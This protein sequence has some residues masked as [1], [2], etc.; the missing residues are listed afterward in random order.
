[1]KV[2]AAFDPNDYHHPIGVYL[3]GLSNSYAEW[4]T[5]GDGTISF[6]NSLGKSF[7]IDISD[8]ST[9]RDILSVEIKSV[10]Y[11]TFLEMN[12]RF[13]NRLTPLYAIDEI[14]DMLKVTCL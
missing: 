5:M 8:E 1:M 11:S 14:I 9:L 4:V 3:Y 7:A 10:E 2:Y 13:H 6:E 12:N